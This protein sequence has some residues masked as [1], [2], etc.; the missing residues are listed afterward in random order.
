MFYLYL[1]THNITGKKYL[2]QTTKDPFKY[3]GSGIYWLR[4]ISV[5]GNDVKTDILDICRD[6]D[7][8]KKIGLYYSKLWSI[9]ENPDF[10]NLMEENGDGSGKLSAESRDKISRKAKG[11]KHSEETRRK[12]S[13]SH[14]DHKLSEETKQKLKTRERTD[15]ERNNMRKSR[16]G[17]KHDLSTKQ[18]IGQSL[19]GREYSE[20]T[21]TKM[22]NSKIGRTFSEESRK[23]MSKSQK[24]KIVS[25]ETKLKM[26]NTHLNNPII[27]CPHCGKNGKGNSMKRWH[28]DNCKS[29]IDK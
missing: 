12:L 22:R 11:R 13:N 19:K 4:H 16:L 10:A 20:E 5:H 21:K 6:K 2:G 17:K 7:E 14:L 24:N 26:K 29:N 23:K 27:E 8:L 28:F 18:K 25:E 9:I 3:K 1:K 15:I